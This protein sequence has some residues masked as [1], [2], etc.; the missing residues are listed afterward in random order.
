M[1][2]RFAVRERG[3][4]KTPSLRDFWEAVM[5][6]LG[7]V[8]KVDIIDLVEGCTP[9]ATAGTPGW[10]VQRGRFKRRLGK[11]TM[12]VL[13]SF[14]DRGR[15]FHEREP[16]IHRCFQRSPMHVVPAFE[17][18]GARIQQ[19]SSPA[20]LL[21]SVMQKRAGV[22]E[23]DIVDLV[24]GCTPAETA[25]TPGWAVPRGRPSWRTLQPTGDLG[26]SRRSRQVQP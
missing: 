8:A 13:G 10:A 14:S 23:V 9:A 5:Q 11:H 3:P 7:G 19:N 20:G 16:R 12:Q 18:T 24:E 1:S 15:D 17:Q 2:S 6:Q 26:S 21:Q 22:G 25:G 4:N